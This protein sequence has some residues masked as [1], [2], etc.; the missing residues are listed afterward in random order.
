MAAG[1]VLRVW[2]GTVLDDGRAWRSVGS[3]GMALRLGSSTTRTLGSGIILGQPLLSWLQPGDP[4]WRRAA[5]GTRP[6]AGVRILGSSPMHATVVATG[7]SAGSWPST[8]VALGTRT[9][10]AL[11]RI[12]RRLPGQYGRDSLVRQVP[13]SRA[14]SCARTQP[15]P[16]QTYTILDITS[17]QSSAAV[18][19]RN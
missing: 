8:W 18:P 4:Q 9:A 19:A 12:C 11:A 7:A 14:G 13:T 1:S 16:R 15:A 17:F 2:R 5:W 3:V 10:R 6:R